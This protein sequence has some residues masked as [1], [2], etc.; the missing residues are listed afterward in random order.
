MGILDI[1]KTNDRFIK[2]L[3]GHDD[4]FGK[5][6]NE[7]IPKKYK[8]KIREAVLENYYDVMDKKEIKELYSY[9]LKLSFINIL[10]SEFDDSLSSL[11]RK[12]VKII[13]KKYFED[14]KTI[15]ENIQFFYRFKELV[16]KFKI[17]YDVSSAEY[18]DFNNQ[19]KILM[20]QKVL[21]HVINWND[22]FTL[23]T[24][25]IINDEIGKLS[26]INTFVGIGKDFGLLSLDEGLSLEDMI[27]IRE[28]LWNQFKEGIIEKEIQISFFKYYY[29][30]LKSKK[31]YELVKDLVGHYDMLGNG[32]SFGSL[33]NYPVLINDDNN[34]NMIGIQKRLRQ[35][36]L[37]TPRRKEEIEKAFKE[38]SDKLNLVNDLVGSGLVYGTVLSRENF[39][40]DCKN[41]IQKELTDYLWYDNVT[42]DDIKNK[43]SQLIN[44]ASL[45]GEDKFKVI[46]IL[47]G[48][49]NNYGDFL[50]NLE[51]PYSIKDLIKSSVTNL[52][53]TEISK[54][55][56]ADRYNNII[57]SYPIFDSISPI[58]KIAIFGNLDD[59]S[60]DKKKYITNSLGQTWLYG[61]SEIKLIEKLNELLKENI[62]FNVTKLRNYI[63]TN[64]PMFKEIYSFKDAIYI[65]NKE[66]NRTSKLN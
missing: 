26:Y 61:V 40:D 59:L 12:K 6:S 47:V 34:L 37:K 10:A 11:E 57:L 3:V 14:N 27:T 55:E 19:E 39:D 48:L 35:Y 2:E 66:I 45:M 32:G 63:H 31:N 46:F 17:A 13:I 18:K 64:H 4:H 41:I 65:P 29:D 62:Q 23:Y 24:K 7:N 1:L 44:K 15:D 33:T 36:S 21:N 53:K 60:D 43:Y 22:D 8:I 56:L 50:S 38:E 49:G 20:F 52:A 16:L 30:V 51:V 42:T 9:Y 58:D 28:K 5:L 25:N 54:A